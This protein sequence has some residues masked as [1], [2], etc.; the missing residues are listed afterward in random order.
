MR[1]HSKT[2]KFDRSKSARAGLFKSL[3]ISLVSLEK[4]TTTEAKAK[5]LRPFVEKLITEGK[6]S[7]LSSLKNII[8][9]IGDNKESRKIHKDLAERFKGRSGGYT[10][11][12]K[13]GRR[14][15]DVAS[16]AII[17]LVK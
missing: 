17:E 13:T 12:I 14:A 4:I 15:K 7:T 3:A 16:M 6:K 1:H 11:V 9:K 2:K 5:A 8:A 10:R